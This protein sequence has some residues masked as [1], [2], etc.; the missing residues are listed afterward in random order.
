M[1]VN[2][3]FGNSTI[4]FDNIPLIFSIMIFAYVYYRINK[5]IEKNKNDFLE[6]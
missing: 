4:Q 5:M 6:R 1:K 3:V 2:C